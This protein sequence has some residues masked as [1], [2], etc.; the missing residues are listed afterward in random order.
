MTEKIIVKM[1]SNK[2]HNEEPWNRPEERFVIIDKDTG[3]ILDD[4]QGYGYKTY[5]NAKKVLWYRFEGGKQKTS[6]LKSEA[7]KFWK[8]NSKI[9]M[10]ALDFYSYNVKELSRNEITEK[11][12]VASV[13]RD[14]GV[15]LDI[16]YLKFLGE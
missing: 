10:F 14:F 5:T 8:L 7:N 2:N 4:A 13:K 15:D 3:E 12:L 1:P 16:K 11:D 6:S 9:K